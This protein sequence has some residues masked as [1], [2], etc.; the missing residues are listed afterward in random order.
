MRSVKRSITLPKVLDEF[1]IKKAKHAAEPLGQFPNYSAALAEIIVH[2][3][4]QAAKEK[5]HTKT[6]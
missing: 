3:R 4:Q 5:H 6:N 1:V 2:A